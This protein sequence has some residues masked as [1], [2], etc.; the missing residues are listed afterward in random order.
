ME[1][2]KLRMNYG[3]TEGQLRRL[4]VQARSGQ[5]NAGLGPRGHGKCLILRAGFGGLLHQC[6]DLREVAVHSRDA[7]YNRP[8]PSEEPLHATFIPT[9]DP[10]CIG[11]LMYT[12]C[13]G[14]NVCS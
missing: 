12:Y 3:L 8:R 11:L 13:P 5:G 14:V 7:G 10:E 1:K 9:P 4:M 6:R 2:Q